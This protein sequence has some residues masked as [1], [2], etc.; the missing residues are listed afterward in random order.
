MPTTI[1]EQVNAYLSDAHSI[2]EQ[3][4][5]QLR[6]APDLA[7]GQ[8]MKDA[9]RDHL[10]ETEDHERTMKWLL[11]GRDDSPSWFKDFVMKIGGKGFILFAR[12]NPDT[13]G[14]LLS[15][16]VS[17]EALEEA[18][19]IL[20]ANVARDAGEAEVASTADRIRAQEAA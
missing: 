14:K 7:Q 2:E 8:R 6:E 15:H 10:V 17:Y 5:A 19:Y 13:P 12:A 3:A 4:L 16:S 1:S 20:L 9:F 11:E 18:S